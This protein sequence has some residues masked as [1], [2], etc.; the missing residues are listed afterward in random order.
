[1]AVVQDMS[2]IYIHFFYF[3]LNVIFKYHFYMSYLKC[4]L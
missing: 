1:M 2:N 3:Q 4:H